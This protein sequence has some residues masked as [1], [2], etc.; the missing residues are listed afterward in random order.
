MNNLIIFF[1]EIVL[2]VIALLTFP[3]MIY[4]FFRYKKYQDSFWARLGWDRISIKKTCYPCIW[5]HAVSVGETKAVSSLAHELKRMYPQAY[6]V[7]SSTTETGQAEAKRSL[8]FANS[9]IYLP[10]DFRWIISP[11]VNKIA[12]NLLILC[13][14][15]FWYNFLH[16]AKKC[17]AT[18][19]LVNGKMSARSTARFQKLPFF[20]K[21]LL[22]VF[23]ILCLQN[24]LYLE[25]FIKAGVQP[26]KISITGNLK[27]D[28]EYPRLTASEMDDWKKRLGIADH[29]LVLAIG[30]THYPEEKLLLEI[31]K[32]IWK[33]QPNLK[34]FLVPRHP[35]RFQE[36]AELLEK[37]KITF[38][39]FT[40]LKQVTGHEQVILIDTMGMLRTCYQLA[41]IALVGGSYTP[42]VGG[43]NILEPCWYGKPVLF[44]PHMHGQLE[45]VH[46]I[47]HY[48][49]GLQVDQMNL[50]QILLKW[51]NNSKE[52]DEIGQQ[53]QRLIHDLGGATH[54]TLKVFS[55]WLKNLNK[56]ACNKIGTCSKIRK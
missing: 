54:R 3:K 13:E 55:P 5:I 53:G 47:N 8:P 18:L 7:I 12:P 11:L 44:G 39:R 16:C 29:Q 41:D 4:Q 38:S 22:N 46:L 32:K 49:A 6:F 17:G 43:H 21:R 42:K 24:S 9:Y 19:A 35:E 50:E 36:V 37:D 40:T 15:D 14:S 20:S 1:Y 56:S 45:L 31:L 23:D 2:W 34:V 33:V 48:V 27:L 26:E 25:R 28:E 51:L 52:R 10:F 30:S